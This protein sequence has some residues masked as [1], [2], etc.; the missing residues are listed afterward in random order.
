ML[1][2]ELTKW[3]ITRLAGGAAVGMDDGRPF[4]AD[5]PPRCVP[6]AV[7]A[8][9][10]DEVLGAQLLLDLGL[11]ECFCPGVRRPPPYSASA[12]ALDLPCDVA[13]EISPGFQSGWHLSYSPRTALLMR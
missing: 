5:L 4:R 10:L 7:V 9:E 8:S 11:E 1:A 12:Q 3:V 13:S 6:R 2:L